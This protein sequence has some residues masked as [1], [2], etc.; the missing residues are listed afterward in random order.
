L[1]VGLPASRIIS[2]RLGL[3]II[4][5]NFKSVRTGTKHSGVIWPWIQR[6]EFFI[7]NHFVAKKLRPYRSFAV[8]RVQQILRAAT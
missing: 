3:I 5:M 4:L 8:F 7:L 2:Y 6:Q 1:L